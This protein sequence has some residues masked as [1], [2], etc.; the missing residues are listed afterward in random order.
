MEK[1]ESTSS[2]KYPTP[3]I[4]QAVTQLLQGTA[5]A[6]EYVENPTPK[7]KMW[8]TVNDP[9]GPWKKAKQAA[10]PEKAET[11]GTPVSEVVAE[12]ADAAPAAAPA[13]AAEKV[14]EK[15][16]VAAA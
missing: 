1:A 10:L 14:K 16:A 11:S 8:M 9:N 6:M 12:K 13:A 15:E 2:M 5:D 7:K 3:W 4:G